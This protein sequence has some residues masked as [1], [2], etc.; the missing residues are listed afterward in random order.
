MKKLCAALLVLLLVMSSMQVFAVT[1]EEDEMP[2]LSGMF[3]ATELTTHEEPWTQE[4]WN[5]AVSQLQSV[6]MDTLVLQYTVQYYSES[7]KVYYYTPGFDDPGQDMNDRQEAVQYALNACRDSGMKLYLGLHLAEDMWFSAMDAGFRDVGKDGKSAFLT[8]SAAYSAQL[9]DDLWAQFGAEYGD[10]IAGWYLPYEFNNTLGDDARNRLVEDFYQPLTNHIKS[11]TPSKKIMISPLL[12]PPMLTEPSQDMLDAWEKLCYDVWARTRVDIIAPQDGCGWESSVRENL[13]LFYEAMAKART[14][15]QT[16][17]NGAGYGEAIAWNNPE[18]YSM[19]GSNTMTMRRF[20]ENMRAVD[21]YVDAHVSFSLHSLTEMEAGKGG[22]NTTNGAFYEAYAYMAEHGKVYEGKLP[23]P[24]GLNA[25]VENAFDAVLSWDRMGDDGLEMPVAGYQI[26]RG[27]A[28]ASQ[29]EMVLL[30]DVPQPG[31]EEATVTLRDSQLESGH[32]YRYEVYAYDGSGNLSETPA[33]TEVTIADGVIAV[34]RLADAAPIDDLAV[35]VYSLSGQ[36]RI[37]GDA[38][39]LAQGSMVKIGLNENGDMA[40]YVLEVPADGSE[41]GL[42]SLR[43]RYSP[44]ENQY[45]PDKIEVLADS[46]LVN[47]LYPQ[48]DYG[49]SM[50]GEVLLPVSLNGASAKEKVELVVTQRHQTVSLYGVSAYGVDPNVTVPETYQ[51]PENIVKGQPVTIG[52]YMATQ[53]F[54]AGDHFRGTDCLTLDY[55]KGTVQTTANLYK[56]SYATSLL[57]RTT[58]DLPLIGWYSDGGN[59]GISGYAA[60]ADRSV[61]L[62]TIGLSGE[63][64]DLTVELP[65]AQA[66]QGASTEWL[67]DRDAT[68][69]LPL[70]V[71]YYGLTV[72][73][74]EELIGVANRPSAPQI[75]FENPPSED[76]CHQ[77]DAYRYKVV[78]D[79]G[80]VYTKIIARVYPQYPAN[81]HFVRGFGVYG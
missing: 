55:T 24:E 38:D 12:Y 60:D 26:R 71:E 16:V 40:Q 68:V 4:D 51:E 8:E 18:L 43:V 30:P 67:L 17:R 46:K 72:G 3:V 19:T 61:W 65:T 27:D 28:Q 29:Q 14:D 75:D 66:I 7:Y 47:T 76:N 33:V 58:A 53:G 6:G 54:S 10:V 73:G 63:S 57:T 31:A 37:A 52:G 44:A 50:T 41:L 22:T 15:A 36:P 5:S 62:R 20:S 9:F 56:G 77:V 70:K 32:T 23:T 34:K 69:F 42:I 59:C 49:N 48:R 1:T 21:Q 25:Q 64:F 80:T 45:F 39:G 81:S 74:V 13:P 78:D 35:K 11:V 79:S 2:L